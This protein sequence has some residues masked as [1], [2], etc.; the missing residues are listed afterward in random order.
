MPM[1]GAL[2]GYGSD[3]FPEWSTSGSEEEEPPIAAAVVPDAVTEPAGPLPPHPLMV[4]LVEPTGT[5]GGAGS[6]LGPFANH[7]LEQVRQRVL[8][9]L[10]HK[11]K[12]YRRL[13]RDPD[14][15]DYEE[16]T[17]GAHGLDIYFELYSGTPILAEI[18]LLPDA[19][20]LGWEL[21][22]RCDPIRLDL[23]KEQARP[24]ALLTNPPERKLELDGEEGL[25]QLY[26]RYRLT[27]APAPPP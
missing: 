7:D 3:P 24:V 5:T 26:P 13:L 23:N 18:R 22:Q 19:Q 6:F 25:R 8:R 27:A 2:D 17:V 14:G 1:I 10:Y 20:A 16:A 21:I 11:A 12:L 9:Y 4:R 15:A